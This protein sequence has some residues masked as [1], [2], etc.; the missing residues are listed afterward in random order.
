MNRIFSI[1]GQRL[2]ILIITFGLLSPT[3]ANPNP[4]IG[5]SITGDLTNYT[6]KKGG[7]NATGTKRS[8]AS[9]DNDI[10]WDDL[11]HNSR[12]VAYRTP[13]GPVETGTSV[14]LRLR[15][16]SGDLTAA[17]VRIFNDRQN[18]LSMLEMALVADDGTYEWWQVTLQPFSLPTVYWYRFIVIDGSDV[19]YYADDNGLLGGLGAPSDNEIDNNW[20]LTI[21]DPNF[22]TPDWVKNAI[23]YQIFPDRFKDGDL[24]NNLPAG[25]LYYGDNST[26]VRS[27]SPYWNQVICDPRDEEGPCPGVYGEN[28][29]GGDLQG[30]INK[31]DYLQSLGV[32]ALYINP[33]FRSPS[34]HGY[35]TTNYQVIDNELGDNALL[36]NLVSQAAARGISVILDGAFNYTSSDSV[37]FDLYQRYASGL[38]ACESL[39][40]YYRDWYYFYDVT[41]GTGSCIG[42]D[43]TAY[44]ADYISWNGI[45]SLP[46][47]NSS[48]HEVQEQ[49]WKASTT[50]PIAPNWLSVSGADGWRLDVGGEIDPGVINDPSNDYW[51]GFREAIHAVNPNAY[52]VGDEW[53]N[54]TSWTLGSEWDGSTNYQLSTAILGFWRSEP[55]TDNDHNAES[56][57]GV[58]EPLLPSQ[59]NERLLNLQER[60]A[61]EALAAMM[62]LLDSHD[63]NRVLFMLDHNTDLNDSTIY[64]N[65]N[66]N[67]S[68]AI[69]RLRGAVLLQMTL[70]GAP[71]IYYGDEVGLVG[72]PAYDADSNTWEDNPYNRNPYPWLDESGTPY[73]LHL[74]SLASQ[75]AIRNHYSLLT[76]TRN[77]HPA[78]R[79]GS[80]DPLLV[81]DDLLIYAYG[82]KLLVP[83]DAAIVVL[84][85]NI[86]AQSVTLNLSGYLPATSVLT[87]VLHA[88]ASY[89]IDPD[90]S[91]T[92]PS[93]P[94]MSGVLLILTSGDLIPPEA[95]SNL[96]AVE[97]ESQ[98]NLTWTTVS[99]AASYQIYRSTVSNGG[100]E[101]IA[102]TTLVN[103]TDSSVTNG[104]QYY[105][106]VVSVKLLGLISGFSN[107]A[108][109]LP[110]WNVD[111]ANLQ[112][113]AE[114]TQIISLTPTESIY[115]QLLIDDITN[116]PGATNGILAQVGYGAEGTSP[117]DWSTWV[118]APY[119]SDQGDND[120]FASPLL[121][122]YTGDFQVVYRYSTTNGRDWIYADQDGI[123]NGTPINPAILH[124]LPGE[125]IISPGTP[126]NLLLVDWGGHF[127]SISWDPSPDEPTL[128]AYDIYRSVDINSTGVPISR[129]Y[130]TSA[131]YLDTHVTSGITYY[132][133]VQAIDTSFNRSNFSNQITATPLTRQVSV[134]FTVDVPNF[135][136]GYVYIV[137]DH[138]KLGSWDPGKILMT[139]VDADTWYITLDFEEGVLLEYKF[140]RGNYAWLDMETALDGNTELPNRRLLVDADSSGALVVN[141]TVAN[142]RDPLVSNVYPA[143]RATEV[144]INSVITMTWNQ[145]MAF[146]PEF[147]LTGP[148]GPIAGTLSYNTST[149]T[150]S[151][152]PY[153]YLQVDTTYTITASYQTDAAGDPQI[154]QFSG[155]F[156]TIETITIHTIAL[157]MVRKN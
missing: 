142:W 4:L 111:W 80:F 37:Y 51:E 133:R 19:D 98:V 69:T 96:T 154:A 84:N 14:T 116:I 122:E 57:A 21:Y 137:G 75:Y 77:T 20:Q 150:V 144:P 83:A 63:T 152:T 49:F 40:S 135:T 155:R 6:L 127:I 100:Y 27:G 119:V 61:P 38:G 157:P 71:T 67:W 70:P 73:Y 113:P 87:D 134:T 85:R 110:H 50:I 104:I 79:T 35:D 18:T 156:T 147:T 47:L 33:I 117:E 86:Q 1:V 129:V 131:E 48:N 101:R 36:T 94:A 9:H 17:R 2:L 16:A 115:G 82:R 153:E 99:G 72:P 34:N 66:Y 30:V 65:P 118:D 11:G 112:S 24:N 91:L 22:Q 42:S 59:L 53:G 90:G 136:E 8:I 76:S 106:V 25:S 32:T 7:H 120:Q 78:L 54:A 12:D 146:A 26:I 13:P 148:S 74:Q 109:T 31:L 89:F 93:V 121:P 45:D 149:W 41:P 143:D 102:T 123:F 108:N 39:S 138:P 29:Y 28:F 128:F 95:P 23:I 132:Y 43:G 5:S 88:N 56:A 139:R 44:G 46:L 10:W 141:D 114:I 105:Y 62:N 68:D 125:D 126:G 3:T 92:I 107:E 124:V 52:I 81:D 55:F 103:Y 60:Y 64:Q 140:T 145:A 130:S 151:F 58:I 97:G 15:A